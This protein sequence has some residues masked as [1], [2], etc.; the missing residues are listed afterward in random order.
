MFFIKSH[1]NVITFEKPPTGKYCSRGFSEEGETSKEV[2]QQLHLYNIFADYQLCRYQADYQEWDG[3]LPQPA[4]NI[5][6]QH[7]IQAS[8][9]KLIIKQTSLMLSL[10]VLA[11]TESKY[12]FKSVI[13]I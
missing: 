5:L 4:R 9:G 12:L 2:E 8:K 6:H 10:M 1:R 7:A 13:M 3:E 11:K